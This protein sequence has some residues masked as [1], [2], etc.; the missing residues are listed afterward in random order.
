[1]ENFKENT[2]ESVIK[3]ENTSEVTDPSKLNNTSTDKLTD[4]KKEPSIQ[5]L[6][7]D[8]EY[9]R[10][11]NIDQ[12]N[13]V[14]GW[15][16]LR[17]V[18]GKES[19]NKSKDVNRSKVQPK[20]VR[21]HNEWRY[22]ALSEPFLNSERMFNINPRTAKD[23]PGA[24][25]NQIVINWQFDTQINKVDFID[26]LVRTTVDEGTCV[27]RTGWK[28][29]TET[30]KVTKPVYSY[31]PIDP[32]DEE[33]LQ[34]LTLATEAYI[35]EDPAYEDA[36]DD[37]KA[38]VE[39]S[40]ENQ[41]P[42]FAEQTD[43]TEEYEEQV[44]VNQPEVKIVDI[45][46][47]FI[48]PSCDGVW[49]D[50]QYMIHT[51]SS[52]KSALT[53]RG[54]F[55]NL[56]KVN[57]GAN[58]IKSKLGSQDHTSTAPQD[59]SR[60]NTDKAQTLVYEYWGLYDI[61]DNGIMVPIVVTWIGDT[62]IQITENPFPD[63]KPP[64]IIIP[65]MP[66]LKSSFG[67]ADASILEENQ[68]ITGAVTRGMIDLLGRSA[69]A[70]MG[71]AKGF[72]DPVNRKRFTSGEDFEFNPNGDPRVQIQQMKYPEIPQSALQISQ[73]QNAE[74]EGLSG[75][76]GYSGGISGDSFGN[77]ARG[78]SGAIDA[79][80]QREMS[81]LRRL[82]E[83]MRILG[84][85]MISMNQV[86]MEDKEVIRVTDEEYVEVRRE[87]LSGN[88]DLIVDIST[89]SVDETKAQ[90]LGF[91]L[92]TQGPNM[93]P[94]LEQIIL[95]EIADLKR[96]PSLAERIRSYKPEPDP[97]EV[98]LR[99][100]E[101]AKLEADIALDNARAQEALARAENIA[102]DTE[103][104][105]TG[106]S[107]ERSI[108]SSGAQA[109]G[110]RNLEVT[111]RLLDGQTAPGNIEAAVGFNQLTEQ[112]ESRATDLPTPPQIPQEPIG[113]LQSAQLENIEQVPEIPLDPS[114][115]LEPPIQ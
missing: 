110:N 51:Y 113:P 16:A 17:N 100:L 88:F 75:I 56:D 2:D 112:S 93:D 52:T 26:R 32:S 90:D 64:F 73:I 49:E 30:V 42:V 61:H 62:I 71:Y 41:I 20:L 102:L 115:S 101:I 4:W 69:N 58:T 98:K 47:F 94:G 24:R 43:E 8:L 72:L 60:I 29:E 3:N 10:Q 25:Q 39:Y 95:S 53:K 33:Q 18:S 19:G 9:S 92:Q 50:A 23:A 97:T 6:K 82:A 68:R 81:I 66:I 104:D 27:L 13:N 76:K 87:D 89:Q 15:L 5:D 77:V 103:M 109:R 28:R 108:E 96:M 31:Y 11:E 7:G 54:I 74:A 106:T 83:G 86:F 84:K 105:A 85:K 35:N 55:S 63:R 46:N 91:M 70:Q 79:A 44:T 21:K 1:M 14:D 34:I 114:Q 37:L 107:H 67:E 99:E 80:G 48:D 45:R 36:P 40:M 59:D 57:W 78:I 12:S 22:P 111:K 65:Y 38:S